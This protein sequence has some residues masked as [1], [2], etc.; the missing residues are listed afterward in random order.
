[1]F[2]V[3]RGKHPATDQKISVCRWRC[4]LTT[5]FRFRYFFFSVAV[6]VRGVFGASIVFLLSGWF[7]FIACKWDGRAIRMTTRHIRL[8]AVMRHHTSNLCSFVQSSS[9]KFMALVMVQLCQYL[10]CVPFYACISVVVLPSFS[11]RIISGNGFL[12]FH[13]V[14]NSADVM[15]IYQNLKSKY[16]RIESQRRTSR[17]HWLQT[18]ALERKAFGWCVALFDL[19]SRLENGYAQ[20][21]CVGRNASHATKLALFSFICICICFCSSSEKAY[22]MRCD[23]LAVTTESTL[24][25]V[26]R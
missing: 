16:A 11:I 20:R 5:G 25:V 4:R 19:N 1:M 24:R 26:K 15:W 8:P 9:V 3:R 10:R 14:R 7:L 17:R 13:A 12:A 2:D 23:F 18:S 6:V 21:Q 22:F